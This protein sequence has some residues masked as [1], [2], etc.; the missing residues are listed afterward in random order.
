[1]PIAIETR[2][3]NTQHY[4]VPD[5]F[6]RAV[7]GPRLK[8]S[9]GYWPNANTTMAESEIAMLELYCERAGLT[10]GMRIVDLGCGWGR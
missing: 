4:E 7:L 9:S 8:Y 5:E 10:D 2:T 6:Y 1:M 3:A